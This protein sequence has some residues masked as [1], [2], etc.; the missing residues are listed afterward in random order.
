[1]SPNSKVYLFY[2]RHLESLMVKYSSEFPPQLKQEMRKQL[3]EYR[4]ASLRYGN[5]FFA[6][7]GYWLMLR[8]RK[9]FQLTGNP[10]QRLTF[11]FL[12]LSYMMDMNYA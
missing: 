3:S 8:S 10:V 11:T 7:V 1:M 2:P 4:S 5:M 12:S 6:G 9:W